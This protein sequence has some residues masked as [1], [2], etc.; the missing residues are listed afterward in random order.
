MHHYDIDI[1]L[2]DTKKKTIVF[3]VHKEICK[4][5]YV[6]IIIEA[7]ILFQKHAP[8]VQYYGLSIK[9]RHCWA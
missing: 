9:K 4:V 7:T 6:H 5:L 2:K 3:L 1:F 8:R